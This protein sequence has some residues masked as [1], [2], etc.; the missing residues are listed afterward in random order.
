MSLGHNPD[1]CKP[2]Y[3]DECG[4]ITHKPSTVGYQ[5]NGVYIDNI[6]SHYRNGEIVG[7]FYGEGGGYNANGQYVLDKE[8]GVLQLSSVLAE[9]IVLEYVADVTKIDGNFVV[10]PYIIET[11]KAYMA[12]ASI[13]RKRGESAQEKELARRDYYNERRVAGLRFNSFTMEEAKATIRKAFKLSPK[14]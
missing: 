2:R 4:N 13:R 3:A 11:V 1:L 12:W 9:E 8:R 14:L 7:R 10:H 6:A 5:G